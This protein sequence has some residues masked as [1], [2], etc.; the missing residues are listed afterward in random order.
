M[1]PGRGS[2]WQRCSISCIPYKRKYRSRSRSRKRNYRKRARGR[3]S[4]KRKVNR[5]LNQKTE[6]KY[7]DRPVP[8]NPPEKLDPGSTDFPLRNSR[9]WFQKIRL[10]ENSYPSVCRNRFQLQIVSMVLI[11]IR[12]QNRFDG[13]NS[14]QAF[15]PV[16]IQPATKAVRCNR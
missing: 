13:T 9:T 5:I 8:I 11:Q 7:Y 6:T 10:A 12:L 16:L 4:L 15:K 2:F 14:N 1:E 3:Y